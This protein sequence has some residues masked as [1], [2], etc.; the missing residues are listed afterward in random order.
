MGNN[1]NLINKQTGQQDP[2]L[3]Q[4]QR[5]MRADKGQVVFVLFRVVGFGSQ[6]KPIGTEPIGAVT[7]RNKTYRDKPIGTKPIRTKPIGT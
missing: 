1:W 4:A 7:Y 6:T 3:R 5:E 2:E